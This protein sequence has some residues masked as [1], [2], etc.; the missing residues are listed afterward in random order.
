MFP[1]KDDLPTRSTPA[2]TVGLIA[3]NV[4]VFVYQVSLEVGS[5][6]EGARAAQDFIPSCR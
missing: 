2:V 1:L 3:L 6:G 4:L 5:P